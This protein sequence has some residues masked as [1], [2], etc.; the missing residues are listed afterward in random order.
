MIRGAQGRGRW[1]E[2]RKKHLGLVSY[3]CGLH[4]PLLASDHRFS[5]QLLQDVLLERRLGW[6][7]WLL[8]Q[9]GLWFGWRL[10]NCRRRT[11]RRSTLQLIF[12]ECRSVFLQSETI[13]S[14]FFLG[15]IFFGIPLDSSSHFGEGLCNMLA[16]NRVV[17]WM[18]IRMITP[19]QLRESLLTK[20]L[21]T[22]L[23]VLCLVSAPYFNRVNRH[24]HYGGGAWF[25]REGWAGCP[26]QQR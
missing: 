22:N 8:L 26:V 25:M 10:D 2:K 11:S 24:R 4:H 5:R 18:Q 16:R 19:W 17:L 14:L 6:C 7:M 23:G 13:L 21:C 9:L 20:K 15:Q 1:E 3:G 12:S